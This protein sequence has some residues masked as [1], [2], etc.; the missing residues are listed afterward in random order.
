MDACISSLKL[1]V[2]P[3]IAYEGTAKE[4]S[5]ESIWRV[6]VL[7]AG[8]QALQL[9]PAQPTFSSHVLSTNWKRKR[10]RKSYA[11]GSHLK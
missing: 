8:S 11:S 9:K 1:Q 6:F 3:E 2:T 10:K 4:H 5:Q 7:K